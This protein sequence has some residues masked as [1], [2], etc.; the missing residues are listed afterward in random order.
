MI[1]ILDNY[2]S[3]TYNVYHA[4]GVLGMELMVVRN[5]EITPKKALELAPASIVI[6]PGPGRPE[7]AGNCCDII[8]KAAGKIPIFGV[9]LGHQCIGVVLGGEVVRAPVPVHG[10]IS[11]ILH[12]G[13][14]I[15]TGI[16][17]PFRATRYHS[18][19]VRE[20]SLPDGVDVSAYTLD[21]VVMGIRNPELKIEG[22]QFHPESI[23]SP[24]GKMIF[25]NYIDYFIKGKRGIN[26][27]MV[28]YSDR[29]IPL[30]S[31]GE[32]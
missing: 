30:H 26:G 6:S 23:A 15:Y 4:L 27:R 12:D 20:D 18:L 28:D 22:V 32:V 8:E 1:L 31:A 10:K 9:C 19:C 16:R 13:K 3:F 17:N 14:T 2:D 24:Q 25:Q 5:D 7:D 29:V 21:G 11:E